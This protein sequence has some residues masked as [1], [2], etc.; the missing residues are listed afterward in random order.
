MTNEELTELQRL[1]KRSDVTWQS[2]G[3]A[4]D[5][6]KA[7]LVGRFAAFTPSPLAMVLL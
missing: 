7:K 3:W 6:I 5:G 2:K 4:I 1:A